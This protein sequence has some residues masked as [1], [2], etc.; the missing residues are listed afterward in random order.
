VFLRQGEGLALT[1]LST[2]NNVVT[3]LNC[4]KAILLNRSWNLIARKLDI[5]QHYRMETSVLELADRLHTDST[6]LANFE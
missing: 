3:K 2:S 1:C 6:L 4:W 5:S